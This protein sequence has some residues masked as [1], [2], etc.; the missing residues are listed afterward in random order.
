MR[1]VI[2]CLDATP[3]VSSPMAL[4]ADFP[5][6]REL[7]AMA[8]R[9]RHDAQVEMSNMVEAA[10]K[11]QEESSDL[12]ARS[13]KAMMEGERWALQLD[14]WSLEAYVMHAGGDFVSLIVSLGTIHDIAHRALGPIRIVSIDDQHGTAPVAF[15]PASLRGRMLALQGQNELELRG[16]RAGG[17]WSLVGAIESV[18]QDY[19][20]FAQL[21][22][23]AVVI[24]MTA[25][26]HVV[27]RKN[28]L[29]RRR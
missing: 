25:I 20:R 24:P 10:E 5:N 4:E 7:W 19:L 22:S 11:Q 28:D 23:G 6:D 18:N 17:S 27:R 2:G 13:L 21:N 14:G 16:W 8:R 26:D 9:L 15:W 12:T 1:T 3:H 29:R